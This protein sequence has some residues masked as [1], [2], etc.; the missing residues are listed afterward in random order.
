MPAPCA[1]QPSMCAASSCVPPPAP[2]QRHVG[3]RPDA[4][5]EPQAR[6]CARQVR[7]YAVR[8]EDSDNYAANA[9]ARALG[10]AWLAAACLA[11]AGG[12]LCGAPASSVLGTAM[13]PPARRGYGVIIMPDG[14]F[15]VPRLCVA[16]QCNVSM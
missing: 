8:R 6:G 16:Y 15:T 14:P 11:P 7:A 13:L 9:T 10:P 2:E 4:T 5:P 12:P 1:C 3:V